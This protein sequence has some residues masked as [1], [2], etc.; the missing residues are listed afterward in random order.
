M[1]TTAILPEYNCIL[2]V[3][4]GFETENRYRIR[5]AVGQQVYFAAEG[6]FNNVL[7]ICT[8]NTNGTE[9]NCC[10]RQYCGPTRP[11]AMAITDNSGAEVIHLER[12]MRC[13]S[14]CCFCCLQEI[15]VQ[16]PPGTII[17]YVK[18]K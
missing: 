14:F 5:N 12:P 3:I 2:I 9:S 18:Q 16:S 8:Y 17:G 4:T 6:T 15:E 11:F 13:S 7:S 10:L 1:Y